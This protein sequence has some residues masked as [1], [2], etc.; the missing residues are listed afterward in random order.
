LSSI[1]FNGAGSVI[2]TSGL[3]KKLPLDE[4]VV[5]AFSVPI[6]N[7]SLSPS[8]ILSSVSGADVLPAR[9]YLPHS[10]KNQKAGLMCRTGKPS[11]I[12]QV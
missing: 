3:L 2:L 6:F 7:A 11:T 1:F 5:T 10:C 8:I 4:S 12:K 9:G